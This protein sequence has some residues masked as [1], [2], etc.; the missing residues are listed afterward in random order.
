MSLTTAQR[1]PMPIP[2]PLSAGASL[3]RSGSSLASPPRPLRTVAVR[4][5]GPPQGSPGERMAAL[6]GGVASFLLFCECSRPYRV[7]KGKRADL[8]G[9]APWV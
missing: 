2:V 8:L 5:R 3:P 9:K 4:P 1:A 7:G 6:R